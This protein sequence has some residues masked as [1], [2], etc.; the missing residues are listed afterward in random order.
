MS[1]IPGPGAARLTVVLLAVVSAVLAYPWRSTNDQWALGV[2]VA[3]ALASLLW[4][5]GRFLTTIVAQRLRVLLHRKAIHPAPAEL[6]STGADVITT[7]LARVES[8]ERELPLG[9]LAGYLDRYGLVCDSVRIT[10]RTTGSDATTWIGL[11]VSGARNLSALQGRSAQIPLRQ[12]AENAARRL[13]G[14]L[15]E[16]GWTATLVDSHQVPDLATAGARERWGT[17]TDERGYLTT[18]AAKNPE[19]L[20]AVG[21]DADEAW[22]VVEIAGTSPLDRIRAAA[23]IRT[24]SRPD[25]PPPGLVRIPGRQARALAALHPLSGARLLN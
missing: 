17:V 5:R 18:Y 6:R 24:E 13:I 4:W 22:T 19:A 11:T 7:V 1:G 23:T 16:T 25:A 21:A 2:A 3:V 10:T 15:R 14:Q 12:T 8:R 20:A 9:L